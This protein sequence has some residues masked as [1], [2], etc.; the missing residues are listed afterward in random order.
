MTY[1]ELVRLLERSGF[2]L[3]RTGKGS[4]RFYL[5]PGDPPI[6]ILIHYHGNQDVKKGTLN[7]VLRQ[8]KLKGESPE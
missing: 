5:K 4:A 8:A 1:S 6:T 3:H 2:R 7:A